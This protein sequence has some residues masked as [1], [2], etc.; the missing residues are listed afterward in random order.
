MRR[1]ALLSVL[2]ISI[3]FAG[4]PMAV[5]SLVPHPSTASPITYLSSG[6]Q[7]RYVAFES[8]LRLT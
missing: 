3:L 4:S 8:F 7:H 1:V 2:F 6:T 5:H